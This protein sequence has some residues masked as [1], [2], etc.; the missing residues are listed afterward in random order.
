MN[1]IR[2]W[3][4]IKDIISKAKKLL[5]DSGFDWAVCGGGAIDLFL[6]KTTRAHTDLDL[7][8]F[9][10][11][12]D[13]IISFMLNSGWRVFEACGG[14][15]IQELHINSTRTLEK[16]NLFCFTDSEMRVRLVPIGNDTYN[17]T[18]KNQKQVDFNYVEFLFNERNHGNFYFLGDTKI[19]QSLEKTVLNQNGVSFLSPEIVLLYKSSYLNREDANKHFHDF[20]EV[21]PFM[22]DEQKQ[23]LRNALEILHAG[24]HP[25][26][27]EL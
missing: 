13:M 20:K 7:A 17:F 22:N 4:S 14:G 16:R 8:V 1:G 10:E 9:W 24:N 26:L 25:W 11:E 27:Q 23:W 2:E 18:L 6:N 21:L 3:R 12:R 5:N 19:T 15:I